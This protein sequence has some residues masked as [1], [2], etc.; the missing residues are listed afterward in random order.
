MCPQELLLMLK[1]GGSS[2][3]VSARSESVKS[4]ACVHSVTVSTVM[5]CPCCCCVHSATVNTVLLCPQ[6]Y[7][8]HSATVPSTVHSVTVS[9]VL[10]YL[11]IQLQQAKVSSLWLPPVEGPLPHL[12]QHKPVRCLYWVMSF[13]FGYVVFL[14]L[15]ILSQP[16]CVFFTWLNSLHFAK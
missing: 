15:T 13:L 5:L 7:C 2:S 3:S 9:T 1:T 6:C 4:S 8:V 10:L 12:Q 11:S 14:H 16:S